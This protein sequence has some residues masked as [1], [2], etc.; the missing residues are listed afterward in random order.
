MNAGPASQR[1]LTR[2]PASALGRR[3]EAL[4]KAG[5]DHLAARKAAVDLKRSR[6]AMRPSALTVWE[7]YTLDK[8]KPAGGLP[9]YAN[10]GLRKT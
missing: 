7:R 1:A 9:R 2:P 5:P 10:F 6:G 4:P 8:D 3:C